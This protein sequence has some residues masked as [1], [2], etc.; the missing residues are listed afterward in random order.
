MRSAPQRFV[1]RTTDL[2]EAAETLR[3]AFGRV[4]I[5]PDATGRTE[6]A[7]RAVSTPDLIATRWSM[8]GLDGGTV[9][10][11]GPER[12]M[13]L[14]GVRLDGVFRLWSRRSDVDCSRPFL[15]PAAVEAATDRPAEAT[16]AVARDAVDERARALTG[17]DDFAVRFTGTAPIHP[18]RDGV[19]R[20]TMAYAFRSLEALHD[21]PDSAAARAALVD[22]VTTMLLETFPNTA[23]VA[24]DR[25]DTGGV[26]SAAVRRALAHID[27]HLDA[28]L[29]IV[30]IARAAR[31]TPRGLQAA[32]RRELGITPMA[33]AREGRLAAA[34]T[35]LRQESP[36]TTTVAAVA[37]RW[38][39]P[40]PAYFA[41]LYRRTYGETP[42]RTLE[43]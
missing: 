9:E 37:V 33:Y 35:E 2:D 38:G 41:R 14:T 17:I 4:A 39:F 27:D 36:V 18:G 16:L 26:R 6:L 42:R 43:S 24:E 32:F 15:Y 29:T 21:T 28:A 31:L 22:L 19:W 25:R 5:R 23:L 1:V 8:T 30:D 3:A 40:D 11:G 20:D 10:Q 7:M 13:V 12:P 34:R